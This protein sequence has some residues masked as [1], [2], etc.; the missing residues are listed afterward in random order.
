VLDLGIEARD[1]ALKALD[2]VERGCEVGMRSMEMQEP[3]HQP[4][5]LR[6]RVSGLFDFDLAR[7]HLQL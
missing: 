7:D 4:K 6:N 5:H 1:S 3:S 2:A